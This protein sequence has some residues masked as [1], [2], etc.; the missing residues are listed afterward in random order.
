MVEEAVNVQK[1]L[2]TK[3]QQ[4]RLAW[5]LVI[6]SEAAD[7]VGDP[8]LTAEDR[9]LYAQSLERTNAEIATC[10]GWLGIALAPVAL[11]C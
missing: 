7:R 4:A 10:S 8:A 1:L 3:Q 6:Q 11:D 2:D 5:L 9:A